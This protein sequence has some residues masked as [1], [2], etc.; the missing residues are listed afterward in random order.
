MIKD[1]EVSKPA[2]WIDEPMM[3]D[4]EAS[5][6]K[7]WDDIPKEIPDP[8]A[9]VPD[10]W[11]EEDDGVWEPP[12]IDNPEYKGEWVHPKI[13][14]PDY[15]GVWVHP[16]IDNP[17]YKEDPSIGKYPD[18]GVLAFE[19]WQVKSGTIFDS[20]IITDDLDEA[21]K[22]GEETYKSL[23]EAEKE[24]KKVFDDAQKA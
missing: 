2:D 18:F 20:I 11:D 4:P 5:K 6:P 1:P 19:I 9:T 3:D 15:K 12:T 14:N 16:E 13:D 7:G 10:D 17:E 23:V 24:A 8:D 21:F 22:Y